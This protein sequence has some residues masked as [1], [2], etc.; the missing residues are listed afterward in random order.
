MK[1]LPKRSRGEVLIIYFVKGKV[2]ICST[3]RSL[4]SDETPET[5]GRRSCRFT[6][7]SNEQGIELIKEGGD[8]ISQEHV[9]P[10]AYRR[11]LQTP[12]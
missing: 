12:R 3:T 1:T 7:A 9:P 11:L 2:L 4:S 5:V 10:V 6:T 8:L